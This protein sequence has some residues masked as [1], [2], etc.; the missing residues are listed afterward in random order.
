MVRL[1]F[2]LCMLISAATC[3]LAQEPPTIDLGPR[4]R[5]AELYSIPNNCGVV[6]CYNKETLAQT[7]EKY[8]R[9]SLRRDGYAN[10]TVKVSETKSPATRGNIA[11]E[12][13]GDGAIAYAELLPK[14][15]EAGEKAIEGTKK[16]DPVSVPDGV[17]DNCKWLRYRRDVEIP[18]GWRYAWRF[19]L[20]LGIAMVNHP[21]VQLLH[22]PPDNVL[23]NLQDYLAAST[24]K[25]WAELLVLNGAP[26]AEVDRFQNIIDIAPISAPHADGCK[27]K[28]SYHHFDEYIKALL[29]LWLPLRNEDVAVSRPMVS[30]GGP[31][32][33]WLV[34]V[35]K[36]KLRKPH[37]LATISLDGPELQV[38]TL[39]T[40]HPSYIWNVKKRAN[41]NWKCRKAGERLPRG[42]RTFICVMN[43][44]R[45]DLISACWQVRMG[46]NP[47]A[48]PEQTLKSCK[49]TWEKADKQRE[50]CE[51]SS[52][53][54]FYDDEAETEKICRLVLDPQYAQEQKMGMLEEFSDSIGPFDDIESPY[55]DYPLT[56]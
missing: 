55:D 21:T 31:A 44:M 46:K 47:E 52:K 15:L 5:V 41:R 13:S 30:F 1:L 40:T 32:R 2:S 12:L 51:L 14:F 7:I 54:V 18:R 56:P 26:D 8:L 39:A 17:V 16:M 28:G 45:T 9:A 27:F 49:E 6:F 29:K 42:K 24:T 10:T 48:N 38:P 33:D 34:R 53:Q 37:D 4:D 50:V 23:M 3:S 35:F 36:V 20:P 43:F 25:R 22:F 11:V 19:Y